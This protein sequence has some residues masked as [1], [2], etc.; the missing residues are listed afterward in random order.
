[1]KTPKMFLFWK[2]NVESFRKF[3]SYAFSPAVQNLVQNF[4]LQQR[5]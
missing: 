1:M 5:V 3:Y 2:K 4:L